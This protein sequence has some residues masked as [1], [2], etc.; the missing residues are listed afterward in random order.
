MNR[1]LK[2]LL[3]AVAVAAFCVMMTFLALADK[4]GKSKTVCRGLEVE[5]ADS[6]KFVSAEDIQGFLD[7]QYGSYVGQKLDSVEL[8]RIERLLESKSAVMESEAWT[9]WDGI[10]HVSITQRAP[11]IRFQKGNLGF[12][13]DETGFIF[14]L[15]RSFT[16]GVPVI[17][18][19]I[20]VT[21]TQG[22]KGEL[23]SADEKQWVLDMLSL[24]KYMDKAKSLRGRF[25]SLSVNNDGDI[26]ITAAE[27]GEKI[28]FGSPRDA[29]D[30]FARL[31][32]YY[33]HILP[34]MG[35]GYYKSINVK[36]NGQI[37]CRKDI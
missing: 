9:T 28:I 19:N 13:A 29:G 5:F 35:E 7:K 16:A 2:L 22:F 36:Y 10:L 20:P 1:A 17:E 12:Y 26:V 11:A 30:K 8:A 25:S 6:L 15:H 14:P 32:K 33:S 3:S 18:G 27:G 31:E 4:A 37:I 23:A 34:A 21:I 24:V